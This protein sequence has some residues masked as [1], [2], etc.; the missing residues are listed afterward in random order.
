MPKQEPKKS[1]L[2]TV[3]ELFILFGNILKFTVIAFFTLF[4][5]SALGSALGEGLKQGNVAVIPIKGLIANGD[6][7]F[8]SVA[9]ADDIVDL[10]EEAQESADIKAILL[11][12][13]SPGGTPVATDQIAHAVKKANKTTIAVIG[14]AGAS[15]AYWIASAA[16]KIYANRMSITGS[17]GV[18]ASRLEFGGLLADYNVTYRRLVAGKYKDIG[19]NLR[20]MTREEQD[21]YQKVLDDLHTEFISAVAENRG[22][23]AAH[24]RNLSTGLVFLG[25][26]A[27]KL[28]LVDELGGKDEA[29]DYLSEMLNITA[30]PVS[31]EK[32]K[33]FFEELAGV[34]SNAFYNMGR[35]M[36]AQNAP[37]VSFT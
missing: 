22:L 6:I 10:I 24:V 3:S 30:E 34:T 19:T 15:G 36:T 2:T 31:Y 27:K 16:D 37:V 35:G 21:I 23:D 17:I 11:D 1:K 8:Q 18:Q 20:E 7:A 28:G 13:D 4:I 9:D 32:P 12:I 33:T 14:E 29:L 25:S 5:L 26:E